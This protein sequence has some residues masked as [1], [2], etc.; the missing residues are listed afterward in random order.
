M[1]SNH[2]VYICVCVCVLMPYVVYQH[3]LRMSNELCR[4][5]LSNTILLALC[6]ALCK[7]LM[8]ERLGFLWISCASNW[9]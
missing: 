6:G 4:F 9:L 2:A 3:I 5:E 7:F 8:L 1:Y